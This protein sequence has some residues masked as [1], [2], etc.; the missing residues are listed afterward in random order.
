M[1]YLKRNTKY[2]IFAFFII[3]LSITIS[4][5]TLA[6]TDIYFSLYNNPQILLTTS[7]I[8][9]VQNI[10]NSN[11]FHNEFIKVLKIS[12]PLAHKIINLRNELD[13]F[14]E[15]K[16]LLKIPEFTNID[17]REW[18]EEGIVIGMN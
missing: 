9:E 13:C 3:I 17:L 11:V 7:L 16:D 12:E 6:K 5:S 15:P 1:Q 18:K 14:K 2:S 4:I 10:N 8:P